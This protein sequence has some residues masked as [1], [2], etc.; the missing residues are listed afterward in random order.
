MEDI[1]LQL[2][3][4]CLLSGSL[5]GGGGSRRAPPRHGGEERRAGPQVTAVMLPL[6]P[7][8]GLAG[9]H[10]HL[11]PRVP[12]QVQLQK[13]PL[14]GSGHLFFFLSVSLFNL[15][16]WI[17]QKCGE[18][19]MLR[20]PWQRRSSKNELCRDRVQRSCVFGRMCHSVNILMSQKTLPEPKKRRGLNS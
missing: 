8:P 10:L 6:G 20:S 9:V 5:A 3:S 17:I 14:P 7:V 11:T 2:S 12:A 15:F 19:V 13:S 16:S 1:F 18:C 4:K